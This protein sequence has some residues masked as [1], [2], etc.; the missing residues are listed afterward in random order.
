MLFLFD[1][2]FL[3]VTIWDILD[4]LIVG[5]LIYL[6]YKFFKGTAAFNIFIGIAILLGVWALVTLLEMEMLSKIMNQIGGVAVILLIVVFQPEIRRFLVIL[7]NSMLRR[8]SNFLSRW[9][10]KNLEITDSSSSE[11]Q[12]VNRAVLYMAK[13]KTGALIVL[14]KNQDIQSVIAS[15]TEL[16]AKISSP[17]LISI[18]NKE[19]PLHDGAVVIGNG[20][21]IAAGCILPLSE[22]TELPRRAGL[23]HRAALGLSERSDALV[24][25]VSEETGRISTATKGRLNYD[26]S[27]SKLQEKIIRYSSR[28][29]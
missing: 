13:R 4:I 19:S 14:M 7:G 6:L 21:I 8:R 26:I 22:T 2:G 27:E 23:R 1:I 5:Y 18:F 9:L 17:L 25:I 10:A 16:D 29:K 11:L 20:K 28:P 15:G 24:V 12:L 3:P